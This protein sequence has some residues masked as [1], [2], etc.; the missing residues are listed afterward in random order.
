MIHLNGLTG[1]DTLM[2]RSFVLLYAL[3]GRRELMKK[4]NKPSLL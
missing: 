4:N 2:F 3:G 1:S